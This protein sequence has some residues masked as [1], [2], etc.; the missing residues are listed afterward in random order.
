M[1][2]KRIIKS[3]L[4][5]CLLALPL[6]TMADDFLRGDVNQDDKVNISD[7]T[8]LIDYL[9][10]DR[11][12]DDPSQV[13]SFTANGVTFRMMAVQGGT[14]SMGATEEQSGALSNEKPAHQV[15]LS[16]YYMGETEVTQELWLAVM[17]SNPS[18]FKGDLQR[19][20]ERVSWYDCQTFISQLNALTGQHFR[21]PSEAEWE[22]AA[23]GGNQA[24]GFQ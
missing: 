4:I 16:S 17:G 20:V 23:R 5:L 24:H 19:P 12:P 9:L 10:S 22:F 8:C 15:T 14:F 7:V 11:W 18:G 13:R 21:L 3:V 2:K 6:S 1:N